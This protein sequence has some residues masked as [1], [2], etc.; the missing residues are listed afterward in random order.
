MDKFEN[1]GLNTSKFSKIIASPQGWSLGPNG[2]DDLCE[3]IFS[4]LRDSS[5]IHERVF[6]MVAEMN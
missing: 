3:E 5:L 6:P 1:G 4:F 2:I